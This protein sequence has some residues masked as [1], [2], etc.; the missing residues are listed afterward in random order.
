[1]ATLTPGFAGA[2]I[3]NIC[4][5]AAIVAA[6]REAVAVEMNDFERATERVMAGL[7]KTGAAALMGA[8]QLKTVALHESG[9][10][11]A[12]WFLKYADPLLKVSIVPRSNGALGF[13]QYLP[14]EMSLHSREEILDKIAVTLGGRAAEE[15]FVGKI[16]TGASDDLDKVTKMAYAMISVYGMNAELGLLS[17]RQGNDAQFYKPYSEATGRLMDREARQVVDQE[18]KR[19]KDLLLEKR[20]VVEAL[21]AAL[22]KRETLVFNE[23]TAIMGD[24][25]HGVEEHYKQYLASGNPFTAPVPG[26]AEAEPDAA[27]AAPP[28]EGQ[29][30]VYAAMGSASDET[31][32]KSGGAA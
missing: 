20:E 27:A 9:H 11:V 6:R 32:R 16:S 10:A 24:R 19:V 17:Y 13:A 14:Q 21:S 15:L 3:A 23:L 4:N 31:V 30:P 2:D 29:T 22:L 28:A 5:E 25:P 12:G 26:A 7:P 1:M 8:N 18:Y